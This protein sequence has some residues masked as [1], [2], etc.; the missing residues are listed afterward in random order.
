MAT[1]T[2]GSTGTTATVSVST[3]STSGSTS[4]TAS[5]GSTNTSTSTGSGSGEKIFGQVL[6]SDNNPVAGAKVKVVYNATDKHYKASGDNLV[7]TAT[8]DAQGNYSVAVG[9]LAMGSIVDISVTAADHASVL[10]YG[11]Y[12]KAQEQVDFKSF[13]KSGGDRRMPVGDVIPPLPFDGLL[14]G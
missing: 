9:S 12:S 7:G 4:T 11:K 13:G 10:V 3:E 1:T 5:G 14:P 2:E 8:A 6:D